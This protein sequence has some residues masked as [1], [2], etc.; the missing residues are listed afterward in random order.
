MNKL[1]PTIMGAALVCSTSTLSQA[2]SQDT[3]QL[4]EF[5]EE[6]SPVV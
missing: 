1:I 6:C 4:V 5:S 2:K 3:L